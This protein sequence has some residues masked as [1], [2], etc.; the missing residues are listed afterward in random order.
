[1]AMLGVLE[2]LGIAHG[3]PFEPDARMKK[4]LTEAAEVGRAMA[5]VEGVGSVHDLHI[6]TLSSGSIALSAHLVV[7]SLARW[8][9]VL[10]EEQRLLDE[11]FGIGH[12]TLQPE[13]AMEV[14]VPMPK[15]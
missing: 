13:A 10:E 5:A 11:R 12:V 15:P 4:I 3:R 2:T 7:R 1:M 6:W 14:V 8:P 9:Q